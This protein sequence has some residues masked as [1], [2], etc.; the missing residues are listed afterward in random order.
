MEKFIINGGKKLKGKVT[1]S[2]AKNVALKMMVA[3]CLTDEEVV[4]SN[5]P[6][7][8]D[9]F[10]MAEIIRE[11]GGEVKIS[12]HKIRIQIKNIKS[13]KISLDKAAEIRTSS[14]FLAPLLVRKGSAIIPNPGGCRIGARPIDRIIE[15]LKKMGADIY[16]N[17]N[18]GYFHSKISSAKSFK[19]KLKGT[20]YRFEKSTHTGTE[21]MIIAGVL[22]EGKTRLENAAQEPEIDELIDFLNKMGANIKRVNPRTIVIQ[23]VEKL[24]GVNFSV[25]PDRNE[26]V[27]FAIGAIITGGD[28]FIKNVNKTGLLEFLEKLEKIGGGFEELGNGIRF[29]SKGELE[30]V[31]VTTSPYPGFMTDWQGPWAVLMTKAN[32]ISTIHETVYESRFGYVSELKKMGADIKFFNPQIKNSDKLYNFNIDDDKKEN[33]HAIKIK[34]PAALHNAAVEISDLRAGATLVLASLAVLGQ[35]VVFGVEHL[36]RGYEKFEER[37]KALGANIERVKI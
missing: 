2:G 22:A 26:I 35:S 24:H 1:V 28:V 9:L 15:G 32:G 34:G 14:M 7:I 5:I 21:T 13:S 4:I 33:M 25:G 11:L 37:L 23:G 19:G 12:S 17:R 10:V 18:D 31:D 8:S 29:F 20:T 16:Y 27:T 36:D 30:A 3:A 6:Y